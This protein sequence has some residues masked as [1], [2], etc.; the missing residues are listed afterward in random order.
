MNQ[1]N[2]LPLYNKKLTYETFVINGKK[3]NLHVEIM[4]ARSK[5]FEVMVSNKNKLKTNDEIVIEDVKHNIIEKC[6]K[7]I[8]QMSLSKENYKT[9][10]EKC[11]VFKYFICDKLL[12]MCDK[13]MSQR[14]LED[15]D[16]KD[17]F[18]DILP[19]VEFGAYIDIAYCT[20]K[21]TV[22]KMKKYKI[23]NYIKK[24]VQK[25]KRYRKYKL[26]SR[27]VEEFIYGSYDLDGYESSDYSD[28]SDDSTGVNYYIRHENLYSFLHELTEEYIYTNWKKYVG[29][30]YRDYIDLFQ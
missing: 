19:D 5:Y 2:F 6:L 1:N 30:K 16:L 21:N 25:K 11:K 22:H 7:D 13:D 28:K 12:E 8:Y 24:E 18:S 10:I 20:F 23:W 9:F 3:Y 27:V 4:I 17:I 26:N 14:I 15:K 29:K